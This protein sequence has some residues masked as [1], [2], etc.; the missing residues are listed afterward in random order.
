MQ[1]ERILIFLFLFFLLAI[2]CRDANPKNDK[3]TDSISTSQVCLD[4]IDKSE[5]ITSIL[6]TEEFQKYLHPE[7][8]GRLPVRLLQ[9][10]FITEDLKLYSNGHSVRVVDSMAELVHRIRIDTSRCRDM[11]LGFSIYYPIESASVQGFTKKEQ[12]NWKVTVTGE[13]EVD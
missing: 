4:K 11:I 1:S 6:D 9:S 8:E 13:G 3:A 7:A 5:A 12:G 10:R 2:S